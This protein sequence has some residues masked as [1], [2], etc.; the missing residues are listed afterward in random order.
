M[1]DL[2][3]DDRRKLEAIRDRLEAETGVKVGLAGA[4]RS[5]LRKATT[6]LEA[7]S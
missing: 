1:V 5:L 4:L 7:R 2:S 6:N 3:P